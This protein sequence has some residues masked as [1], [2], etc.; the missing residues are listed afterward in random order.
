MAA[1]DVTSAGFAAGGGVVACASAGAAALGFFASF[2]AQR[3]NAALV[4]R[5]TARTENLNRDMEISWRLARKESLP[6]AAPRSLNRSSDFHKQF[7]PGVRPRR[8]PRTKI[9]RGSAGPE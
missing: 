5:N 2:C 8:A 6:H 3:G 7:R 1:G 9:P 4:T